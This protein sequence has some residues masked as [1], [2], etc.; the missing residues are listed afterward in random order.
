[1]GDAS[2]KS[3]FGGFANNKDTDQPVHSGSDQQLCHS[4][5]LE[6]HISELALNKIL[7]FLASS[8]LLPLFEGGGSAT[9][10]I[11]LESSENKA[12]LLQAAGP[13]TLRT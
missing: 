11:S 13:S 8:C 4:F 6:S 10:M 1:M 12:G 7:I 5:I 3:V 2:R 9:L